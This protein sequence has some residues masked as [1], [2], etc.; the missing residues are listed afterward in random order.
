[1][2][3]FKKILTLVTALALVMSMLGTVSFADSTTV[4]ARAEAVTFNG[5]TY[6]VLY[7]GDMT[8]EAME[9]YCESLG[10]Y[11][12]CITTAEEDAFLYSYVSSANCEDS[13]LFGFS[14]AANEGTWVWVSG[15]ETDYTNWGSSEPSDYWGNENYAHYY[16][17]Y[18]NGEWNDTGID[19]QSNNFLIEWNYVDDGETNIIPE[20]TV[21]PVLSVKVTLSSYSGYC[22]FYMNYTTYNYYSGSA[23][24]METINEGETVTFG[25]IPDTACTTYSLSV[26]DASGNDVGLTYTGYGTVTVSTGWHFDENGF[27]VSDD[28]QKIM[29]LY[30]F[31]VPESSIAI[32]IANGTTEVHTWNEGEVVTEAT[33]GENGE[34]LYTCSVCGDTYTEVIPATGQ[35]TTEIQNAKDATCTEDGYTGDE[36]CTVCG[37]TITTG[38]T[39][40]ATGHTTEIQNA[41]DATCVEEGY[42]GDEVCTVCGETIN[43]GETI[44]ATGQHNY[45]NGICT[46]CGADESLSMHNY[47]EP[48]FTW[49]SDYS[50]CTVTFVCDDCGDTQTVN[51]TITSETTGTCDEDHEII[52]TATVTFNGVKYTD[53]QLETFLASKH[54]FT[55][56]EYQLSSDYK[57][58]SYLA[59]VCDNCGLEKT[60][61]GFAM[62]G[63]SNYVAP[64]CTTDGSG[65]YA[66]WIDVNN[67]T[68]VI[69]IDATIE[70][71]G[72][73][74]LIEITRDATCTETGVITYT[75]S[76]CGDSY[77]EDI[78]ATGHT[79]EVQN[80]KDATCTEDGYTGDEVCTVC[81][82]TVTTGQVIPATGHSYEAVVTAPTCTEKGYTTYT[83]SVCGDSYVADETEALGHSYEAV[84]TAPTCTEKGYTTYTCSVCGDTYVADETEALGHSYEAVVTAPTCTEKGYTTYTCSVCGDT[85]V[86]DETEAL[87]HSYEAVVTAPTCT[88]KGYTTYTCSVCGDTYV[89]DETEA[90][91]HSYEAVVTAPTCTEKGYTTYTCSV[92]GD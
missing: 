38:E 75:C 50:E 59:I 72:H 25:V 63:R 54:S 49:S 20:I 41:K 14:D 44:P 82:E 29:Y 16:K 39:I 43:A 31:T 83:C 86:A 11:L 57:K 74:Y 18:P 91:G 80:A 21:S 19:S 84:V 27:F 67:T 69:E 60:Y 13:T 1:M 24:I 73:S 5:H 68:Y 61:T 40:P 85:Y 88:E 90:L 23:V 81:S 37:E 12:A 42:T 3:K 36:V 79:I 4:V 71:L 70:A 77:T 34:K 87:G 33:C 51:A 30:T 32:T 58:V 78:P 89:A 35:H 64:T 62:Q 7:G 2:K 92:C 8:W 9:A 66:C 76:V 48:A 26:T 17:N 47:G 45:V 15:E 22:Y 65:E 55:V 6:Q 52:Y 56:T 46:V 53:E 10:G 28:V